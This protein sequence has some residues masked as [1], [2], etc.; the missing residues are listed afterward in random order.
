MLDLCLAGNRI[1]Y[2]WYVLE[3]I[4]KFIIELYFLQCLFV[5]GLMKRLSQISQKERLFHLLW[6][7]SAFEGNFTMWHPSYILQKRS[8][9]PFQV[10]QE[11]NTPG[12]PTEIRA[13]WFILK[14]AMRFPITTS[15]NWLMN[16]FIT[17]NITTTAHVRDSL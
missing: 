4:Q 10:G 15:R 5:N 17:V 12:H 7:P 13:Y 9:S 16:T 2:C 14:I 8:S 3:P 1:L 6:Q 11:E